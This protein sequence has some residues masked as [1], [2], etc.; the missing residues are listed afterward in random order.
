MNILAN[1]MFNTWR[2][3]SKHQP[4]QFPPPCRMCRIRGAASWLPTDGGTEAKTTGVLYL[5]SSCTV[6]QASSGSG[7]LIVSSSPFSPVRRF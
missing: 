2:R 3:M 7:L 6:A 5:P 1:Q 4:V